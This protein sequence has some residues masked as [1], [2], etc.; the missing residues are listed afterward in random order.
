MTDLLES[1]GATPPPSPS[2]QELTTPAPPFPPPSAM[3]DDLQRQRLRTLAI[4]AAL[5]LAAAIVMGLLWMSAGSARDD[6]VAEREVAISERDANITS[7]QDLS[8]ALITTQSDLSEAQADNERLQAEL[9]EALA[10]AEP[11]APVEPVVDTA[12]EDALAEQISELDV[13]NQELAD[14]VAALQAELDAATEAVTEPVAFDATTT[15][16]FSRWVGELLSS[17]SGSSQLAKTQSEC[18]GAAVINSIGLDALGAGLNLAASSAANN[19]VV[20][21]MQSGA[22][23]CG[24]P[25]SL[26]F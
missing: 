11:I 15:P 20:G 2:L 6:A 26:I 7:R 9:D 3:D 24:I 4:I 13:R 23:F 17:R 16:E 12:R 1:G 14:E 25:S 5:A 21:A 22:E 19:L 8:A 18:F 10:T